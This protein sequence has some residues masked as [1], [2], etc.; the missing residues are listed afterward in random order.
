MRFTTM[1]NSPLGFA[2]ISDRPVFRFSAVL[3][4]TVLRQSAYAVLLPTPPAVAV[5]LVE[6]LANHVFVSGGGGGVLDT[7]N[8]LIVISP[9]RQ[10]QNKV[11][12]NFVRNIA[13]LPLI[14]LSCKEERTRFGICL[15][16]MRVHGT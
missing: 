4:I 16:C 15:W 9:Y 11:K 12:N 7:F 10:Q 8:S 14:E 13:T 6:A 5:W 2:S 1:Q 3:Y